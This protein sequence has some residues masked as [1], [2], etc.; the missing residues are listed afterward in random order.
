[1]EEIN[2]ALLGNSFIIDFSCLLPA[3]F[4]DNLSKFIHCHLPVS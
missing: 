4:I 2:K 1:M 3:P